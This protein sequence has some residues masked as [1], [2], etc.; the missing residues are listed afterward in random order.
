[1]LITLNVC[2]KVVFRHIFVNISMQLDCWY[3]YNVK[4]SMVHC[5]LAETGIRQHHLTL[6]NVTSLLYS[7]T[8]IILKS[9]KN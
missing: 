1:M 8:Y 9:D 6:Y 5:T 4:Y 3:C 2:E 7:T